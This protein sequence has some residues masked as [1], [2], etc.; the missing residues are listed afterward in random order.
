MADKIDSVPLLTDADLKIIK[1]RI[2]QT[3]ETH[4]LNFG[5][6]TLFGYPREMFVANA[7][8]KARG[9]RLAELLRELD[10]DYTQWIFDRSRAM[11][12]E[13]CDT[14]EVMFGVP[15]FA[16]QVP[17]AFLGLVA[18]ECAA[19]AISGKAMSDII[20]RATKQPTFTDD[21][22]RLAYVCKQLIEAGEHYLAGDFSHLVGDAT[23]IGL[24]RTIISHMMRGLSKPADL[25]RALEVGN[26]VL[27][28]KLDLAAKRLR[29]MC[30]HRT[31][32]FLTGTIA[33]DDPSAL[34]RMVETAQALDAMR[35]AAGES[36]DGLHKEGQ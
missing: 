27:K 18:S 11:A 1:S 30:S 31:S 10:G 28:P 35:K 36:D 16:R 20:S 17:L 2:E 12:D 5:I 13:I 32:I 34:K 22:A 23:L 8:L 7:D 24:K 33:I 3:P 25:V 9:G 26:V 19:V 21:A 29:D 14:A 6:A 4:R 15:P